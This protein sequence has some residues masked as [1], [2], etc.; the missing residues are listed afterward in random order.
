MDS[1]QYSSGT[2]ILE[3]RRHFRSTSR[4]NLIFFVIVGV[5]TNGHIGQTAKR[6]GRCPS[7]RHDLPRDYEKGKTAATVFFSYLL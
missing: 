1:A 4:T 2:R 5:S 3:D 6:C 7:R